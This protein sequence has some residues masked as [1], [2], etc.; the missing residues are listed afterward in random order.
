MAPTLS[1]VPPRQTRARIGFNGGRIQ[2]VSWR[3]AH[4]RVVLLYCPPH[5]PYRLSH[6]VIPQFARIGHESRRSCQ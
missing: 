4:D 1:E 2:A 5:P 6:L 3:Q